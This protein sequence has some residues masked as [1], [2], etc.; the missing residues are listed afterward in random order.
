MNS[1]IHQT[2][3]NFEIIWVNDGYSDKSLKILKNYKKRDKRINIITQ[4]NLLIY[5]LFFKEILMTLI[6]L[7]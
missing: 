1:L 5:F 6:I 2:F 3:K 7:L 4:K